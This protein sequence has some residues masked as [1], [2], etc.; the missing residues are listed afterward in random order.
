MKQSFYLLLY[1]FPVFLF[2]GTLRYL[3]FPSF[4]ADLILLFVLYMGFYVPILPGAFFV[5][6]LGIFQEGLASS[7]YGSILLSYLLVYFFLRLFHQQL[8]FQR[9]M[10]QW[11]WVALLSWIQRSLVDSLLLWH[12]FP[13][14]SSL[15]PPIFF[16]ILQGLVSLILFPFLK[17]KG[18]LSTNYVA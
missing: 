9:K 12:G 2:E 14:E 1:S 16:A 8:F 4:H 13:G 10:A 17:K 15:W 3:P 5:F 11:I 6:F 7:L 18:T